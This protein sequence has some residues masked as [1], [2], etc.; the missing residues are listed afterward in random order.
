MKKVNVYKRLVA[1]LLIVTLLFGGNAM[2]IH[3]ASKKSTK[4]K[5]EGDYRYQVLENGTAILVKY[6]GKKANV[7][8]PSKLG[9]KKVVKIADSAFA[10]CKK[11]ENITIPDTVKEIGNSAFESCTKLKKVVLPKGITEISDGIFCGCSNLEEIELP[12]SITYIG[13]FAFSSC[14]KL[15]TIQLPAGVNT[16]GSYVFEGCENLE[17]ISFPAGVKSIGA[18]TLSD[19]PKLTRV[20]L[21]SGLTGIASGMFS[22]C[23][24]LTQVNIPQGVTSIGDFAFGGCTSLENIEIPSSVTDFGEHAFYKTKWIDNKKRE[25]PAVVVNDTLID[26]TSFS[27]DV[28]LPNTFTRIGTSVFYGYGLIPGVGQ[29]IKSV[30]IPEGVTEIGVRAF[31]GCYDIE[32]IVIPN[33]VKIIK[34][35]A[36]STCRNLKNVSLPSTTILENNVFSGTPWLE[37][38][39]QKDEMCIINNVLIQ[40]S[41]K[42]ETI[43]IPEQVTHIESDAFRGTMIKRLTI[44]ASVKAIGEDAFEN[45][46]LENVIISD[47]VKKIGGW[48]FAGTSIKSITIPSSVEEIG[49]YVFANCKELKKVVFA[50]QVKEMGHSIFSY[51]TNLTDIEIQ[52]GVTTIPISTF[53]NCKSLKNIVLPKSVASIEEGAFYKC[54]ARVYI[55]NKNCNIYDKANTIP[56]TVAGLKGSTAQAYANRYGKAFSTA[57]PPENTKIK[58]ISA[59]KKGF[60]VNWKKSGKKIKGYEIQYANNNDFKKAKTIKL[61]NRRKTSAKVTGLKERTE[62]YIQIR[63]Y[64]KDKLYSNW[65]DT[66]IVTTK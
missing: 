58:K 54:K 41:Q 57:M 60:V 62:Y 4:V 28:I 25:T 13:A 11:I 43:T 40:A 53:S 18:E 50:A 31:D 24:N 16:I 34:E 29:G 32:Y 35:K 55:K 45:T 48:A 56:G 26:A 5:T 51:C 59:N 14:N 30:T 8:V 21:P 36:F 23:K 15:K 42:D 22:E 44:P 2:P 17:E 20:T 7:T 3:A 12:E 52:E 37:N 66:F 61:D 19:C 6:I 47:G 46:K 63:T 1:I 27:G 64:S 9:K 10:E 39:T 33:S 65:S 38:Q 49:Y